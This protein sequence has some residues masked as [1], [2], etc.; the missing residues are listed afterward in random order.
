MM[1]CESRQCYCS[2][3]IYSSICCWGLFWY[4]FHHIV[5]LILAVTGWKHYICY[6]WWGKMNTS[7]DKMQSAPNFLIQ[8]KYCELR[9]QLFVKQNY[10]GWE[11]RF[12]MC[13][14]TSVSSPIRRA[15]ACGESWGLEYNLDGGYHVYNQLFP[16]IIAGYRKQNSSAPLA[17][18]LEY[19]CTVVYV[20]GELQLFSLL[21][22][23]AS[24]DTKCI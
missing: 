23:S 8:G 22:K 4:L 19:A 9:S 2:K 12:L 13:S 10:T 21:A 3:N 6:A 14:F 16:K 17:S 7:V 15:A 5:I 24:S 18:V 11:R 20:C 1:N